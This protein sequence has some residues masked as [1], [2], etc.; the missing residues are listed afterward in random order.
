VGP[1]T[2]NYLVAADLRAVVLLLF[3]FLEMWSK[4][5]RSRPRAFAILMVPGV[6]P[7]TFSFPP[8]EMWK[9]SAARFGF[10][11]AAQSLP[12]ATLLPGDFRP[13]PAPVSSPLFLLSLLNSAVSQH[14]SQA[15][16]GADTHHAVMDLGRTS[17]FLVQALF[18]S[19]RGFPIAWIVPLFAYAHR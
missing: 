17:F 6:A 15:D 14:D 12:V 11:S 3:F 2:K 5:D 16:V 4:D 13:S 10:G 19:C 1:Q 9:Y 18:F 7:L 8:G